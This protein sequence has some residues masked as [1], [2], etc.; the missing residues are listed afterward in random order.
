[1]RETNEGGPSIFTYQRARSLSRT[2][3]FSRVLD[4]GEFR[5]STWLLLSSQSF[6][7]LSSH[8]R[9]SS[10]RLPSLRRER[11]EFYSLA[12]SR[13]ILSLPSLTM[14]S[15]SS[16]PSYFSTLFQH[17]TIATLF[18]RPSASPFFPFSL[19]NHLCLA[20]L[21]PILPSS[22]LSFFTSFFLRNFLVSHIFNLSLLPSRS[23]SSTCIPRAKDRYVSF[24]FLTIS[25]LIH[26]DISK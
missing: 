14:S 19:V 7:V 3:T 4:L 12:D 2:H 16:P 13:L 6:V 11:K 1:M 21:P 8:F 25:I 15:F 17:D 5:L 22:L 20:Y 18:Q 23:C 24:L 10:S 9:P 26:V